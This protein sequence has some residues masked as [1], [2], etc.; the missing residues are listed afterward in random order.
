MVINNLDNSSEEFLKNY[1]WPG[2]V[3]E[4]ENLFK[5]ICVLFQDNIISS[6][7]LSEMIENIDKSPSIKE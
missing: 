7:M 4:L 6:E 5:R 2:N 1:D 3:R